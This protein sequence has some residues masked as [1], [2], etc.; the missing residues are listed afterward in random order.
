MK[1]QYFIRVLFPFSNTSGAFWFWDGAVVEPHNWKD[2]AIMY[3]TDC[4]T[5]DPPPHHTLV[6]GEVQAMDCRKTNFWSIKIKYDEI[7]LLIW[8]DHLVLIALLLRLL[9]FLL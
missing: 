8:I 7:M 1:L 9:D 4:F 5:E 3:G 2:M 6:F